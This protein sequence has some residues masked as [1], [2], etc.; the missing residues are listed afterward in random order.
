ME[1]CP[2]YRFTFYLHRVLE[3]LEK[4]SRKAALVMVRASY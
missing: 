3:G 4:P 2:E 1:P